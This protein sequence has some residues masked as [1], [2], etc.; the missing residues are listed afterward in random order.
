ML[1]DVGNQPLKKQIFLK[2][3]KGESYNFI[4]LNKPFPYVFWDSLFDGWFKKI[5]K[6]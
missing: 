2:I 1:I 3:V 6:Q 5:E 4:I